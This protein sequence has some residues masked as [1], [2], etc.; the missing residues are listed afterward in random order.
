MKMNTDSLVPRSRSSRLAHSTLPLA[1]LALSLALLSSCSNG[2]SSSSSG[3]G[4][5]TTTPIPGGNFTTTVFLGD[6]LTAGYQ[7][8]SLLDTAEVHG[9]APLVAT[10]AGFGITQALIAPPGAP[11]TL[12][13]KSLSPLTIVTASGTTTGR[14]NP[15]TQV[16]DLAVPGALLNDILS[17][18]PVVS[19]TTGQQQITQLVLGFPGLGLGQDYSQTTFAIKANP[20][21]IF[22]WAGNN[23]ALVADISGMPASMTSLSDFTTQYTALISQLTTMTTAHLVIAN[24]PDVTLVPY[25]QPAATIL[26][27]Y[28]AATGYPT[29]TLS[30]LFG[31]SPGDF[32]NPEGLAEIAAIAA[33]KQTTPVSD[34][35]VLTAAEAVI[36]QQRVTDFNTVIAAQAKTAGATVVDIHAVFNALAANGLTVSGYTGTNSFLGGF[37]SLDGIHPTNTGYAVVANAFID[38]MNSG[39]G[40]KIT[41]INV[42]TVAATD[43]LWPPNLG[44]TVAATAHLPAAAALPMEKI[45]S[46]KH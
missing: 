41:D 17:T 14:D 19:P 2:N 10:Q 12:Q 28:S 6:S 33:G 39:F 38:A 22:L 32:V 31:I 11:S 25:L 46:G 27:E 7:S 13:L 40:S 30:G 42:A 23:D 24:I 34:A 29:S 45:L 21:T 43:P 35:G 44:A 3:S 20:T 8:G 4:G 5:T 1:S 15:S 16:T 37:F 36:V 26:A 9:W 18:A